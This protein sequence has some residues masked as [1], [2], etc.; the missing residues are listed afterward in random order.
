MH[1]LRRELS[2][3]HTHEDT[4]TPPHKAIACN[5]RQAIKMNSTKAFQSPLVRHRASQFPELWPNIMVR[6]QMSSLSVKRGGPEVMHVG[7]VA[8]AVVAQVISDVFCYLA[9]ESNVPNAVFAASPRNVTETFP[10][11]VTMDWWSDSCWL[12]IDL[13]SKG[14]LLYAV[15]NIIRTDLG[16]ELHPPVF[17]LLWTT[18]NVAR[19]CL[20]H[21]WDKHDLLGAVLLGWVPPVLAL[22][23]L[24]VSCSHLGKHEAWLAVNRPR[25]ISCTRYLIQNGLAA[26]AWWSLLSAVLGL[27]VALKYKACVPDPLT[28]TVVLTAVS[29]CSIIWFILQSCLLAKYMRHVF[30][31]YAILILGLGAMFTRSY[32]FQD[33]AA[34]TVYCGFLMLLMTVMNTIHTVSLCLHADESN[35]PAA[36]SKGCETVWHTDLRGPDVKSGLFR[37]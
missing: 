17:Y 9:K 5:Q 29:S 31:V 3:T 7:S 10:L 21:L 18:I 24:Y 15:F 27:G 36:T 35:K 8:L 4:Q 2:Y 37:V 14:W 28:S 19:M 12:I 30:S 13:W 34:N 25:V 26:F 32:R 22:Y 23:M 16:P 1:Q 6:L 33:L 20:M 11:E